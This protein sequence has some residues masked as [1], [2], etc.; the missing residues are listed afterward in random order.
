M[1]TLWSSLRAP[2]GGLLSAS[3]SSPERHGRLHDSRGRTTRSESRRS[4]HVNQKPSSF[5]LGSTPAAT[6]II[7]ETIAQRAAKSSAAIKRGRATL[8]KYGVEHYEEI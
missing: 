8:Q 7:Q 2:G 6:G 5:S 1:S 4:L 3:A